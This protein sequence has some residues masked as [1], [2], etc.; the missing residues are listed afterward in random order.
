MSESQSEGKT[1]TEIIHPLVHSP[2]SCSSCSG[3]EA[4]TLSRDTGTQAL[5]PSCA[6]F[7]HAPTCIN[8]LEQL[9]VEAVLVW[10]AG[11]TVVAQLLCHNPG[12]LPST[13]IVSGS[14]LFTTQ[15]L[16]ET[17]GVKCLAL[18]SQKVKVQ[19]L[20]LKKEKWGIK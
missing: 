1:E 2:H 10:G 15:K 20:K 17:G 3:P 16:T 19:T 6:A 18:K 11:V 7:P 4:R 14:L 9:E 8:R 12:V 5:G 13:S